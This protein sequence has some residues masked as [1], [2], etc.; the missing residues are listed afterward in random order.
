LSSWLVPLSSAL[1]PINDSMENDW[2]AVRY[3]L[4]AAGVSP[5]LRLS[6]FD[7]DGS[8]R[9]CG[10]ADDIVSQAQAIRPLLSAGFLEA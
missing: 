6:T 10:P 5:V 4:I 9:S 2:N 1:P 8:G 7:R 3:R